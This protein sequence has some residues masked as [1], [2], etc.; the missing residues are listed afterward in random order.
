MKAISLAVSAQIRELCR[1]FG[2]TESNEGV[3]MAL[4]LLMQEN[5]GNLQ[6]AHDLIDTVGKSVF[7]SEK[8][9]SNRPLAMIK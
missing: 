2:V 9:I 3:A 7:L 8:R 6:H 4:I 1:N 5:G